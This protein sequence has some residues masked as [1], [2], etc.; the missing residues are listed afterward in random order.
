MSECLNN[1]QFGRLNNFRRYRVADKIIYEKKSNRRAEKFALETRICENEDLKRYVVKEATFPAGKEHVLEMQKHFMGLSS[2]FEGSEIGVLP[3]EVDEDAIIFPFIEGETLEEQVDRL[4]AQD[5]IREAKEIVSNYLETI[6]KVHSRNP[7][8][9]TTDFQQVFGKFS[10]DKEYMAA[11]VSDIDAVLDNVIVED[12]KKYL[13]DYE[14]TFHFPI[15]VDFILFRILH[16]FVFRNVNSQVLMNH[17]FLYLLDYSEVE[18]NR[19]L[20]M[21]A[22]FQ[23]YMSGADQGERNKVSVEEMRHLYDAK[24]GKVYFDFGRG[25]NERQTRNLDLT[26]RDN[27]YQGKITIPQGVLSCRIDPLEGSYCK[28]RLLQIC[29][30]A[31][32]S[33]VNKVRSN[34]ILIGDEWYFLDTTDPYFEICNP[35]NRI[36]LMYALERVAGTVSEDV[37][38]EYKVKKK[39]KRITDAVERLGHD[40]LMK[41]DH[42]NELRDINY[43]VWLDENKIKPEEIT[44]QKKQAGELSYQPRISLVVWNRKATK[45]QVTEMMESVLNQTYANW[46]L[47]F[48]MEGKQSQVARMIQRVYAREDSRITL[49]QMEQGENA[50]LLAKKRVTGDYVVVI[51]SSAVLEPDAFYEIAKEVQQDAADVIYTDEDKITE[52]VL[53]YVA[54]MLK[55]DYSPDLLRSYNYVGDLFVVKKEIINQLD[56]CANAY[57][58]TFRCTELAETIMHLPRVLHHGRFDVNQEMEES[59]AQI[60]ESH[61]RRVGDEGKVCKVGENAY[62]HITYPVKNDP[63]VSVII[64]NKDHVDML[65]RCIKSLFEVNTYANIEVIIVEN[66]STQ[67]NA[68]SFYE[69]V[70]AQNDNVKV[71]VWEQAFNFS[72]INNY[73]VKYARG[74]YLLLLNNDTEMIS[75]DAIADMLGNCMRKD[76]GAVGAKLLFEDDTVQHGGVI[77]GLG[78]YAGHVFHGL[79]RD[80]KGYMNRLAVNG[81]YNAV[82]AACLMT[83]KNVYEEVRGL[84]ETYTVAVNDVDYCLKL[85]EKGYLIVY[86]AFAEWHHYESK[87]RGYESDETK[88]KRFQQEVEL[89]YKRWGDLAR[90][91]DPYYN[92]NFQNMAPFALKIDEKRG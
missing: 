53:D 84:T 19:F 73:G 32:A 56:D 43:Q 4:V 61:L 79:P 80:A 18:T 68:F 71:V 23:N 66:H 50:F 9:E 5:R 75:P 57:D 92:P 78:G 83:K 72:A 41:H 10:W 70:Q 82:T 65:E 3:C 21:E 31:G 87:T 69:K 29:D 58:Y 30:A 17:D 45:K 39:R 22:N 63:L 1:T 60:I 81:N 14:W 15:P 24:C 89:F 16:Y 76:V 33:L 64:P 74:E 44:Q 52:D 88:E 67:K 34:G 37:A 13:I 90:Q 20:E 35:G 11:D 85:R 38:R 28:V 55:P 42:A 47:L 27:V 54:P 25:Y 49:Y 46:E 26:M 36:T 77:L 48:A 12:G 8:C 7:F 40:T 86:D 2:L 6:R 62:Y 51:D 59:Q 91:G